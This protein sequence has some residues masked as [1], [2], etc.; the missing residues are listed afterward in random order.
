MTSMVRVHSSIMAIVA[1]ARELTLASFSPP[2]NQE[3]ASELDRPSGKTPKD[4][5]CL[6]SKCLSYLSTYPEVSDDRFF[7]E[8]FL[9]G[10]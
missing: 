1:F 3:E 9:G 8:N 4:R 6:K 2:G 5:F 7:R 10:L